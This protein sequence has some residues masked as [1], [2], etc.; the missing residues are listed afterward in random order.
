MSSLKYSL[1]PRYT[2]G[3]RNYHALIK[4]ALIALQ[5][6]TQ[7]LNHPDFP[8]ST[9]LEIQEFVLNSHSDIQCSSEFERGLLTELGRGCA[10]RQWQALSNGQGVVR[11]RAVP[12]DV[13]A[14]RVRVYKRPSDGR[15]RVKAK[16]ESE[17]LAGA[18]NGLSLSSGPA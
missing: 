5:K 15:L 17:E 12:E 2:H 4:E 3:A 18:V 11:Y 14:A 7:H 10:S 9:A 16:K 1:E 13:V 6:Q 8:G